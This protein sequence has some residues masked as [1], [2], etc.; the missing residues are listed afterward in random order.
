MLCLRQLLGYGLGLG[1]GL[2][3][4]CC[5]GRG[6]MGLRL[7][8]GSLIRA[9]GT[10]RPDQAHNQGYPRKG[11]DHV[12]AVYPCPCTDHCLAPRT[13]SRGSE[14]SIHA[15][16]EVELV[17][18]DS[19]RHSIRPRRNEYWTFVPSRVGEPSASHATV[20]TATR[21][22]RGSTLG[23]PS[24]PPRALS[25]PDIRD[26]KCAVSCTG[27]SVRHALGSVRFLIN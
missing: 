7:Y 19:C 6:L 22:R 25:L 11:Q 2:V 23:L 20:G 27:C 17:H 9:F 4:I 16:G 15:V 3:F 26:G 21:Y 8:T 18:S 10:L 12:S 24:S 14:R 5:S 1:L 13:Q